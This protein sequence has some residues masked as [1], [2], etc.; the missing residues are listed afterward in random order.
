MIVIIDYGMGNLR[1]VSKALEAIDVEHIISNDPNSL[2]KAD[3]ILLPGVGA[4]GDGM[5]NL[6]QL[7]FVEALEKHV[8]KNKKPLLGICLGM[9]LLAKSSE[10]M[11]RHQ[12]L[13]FIDAEI[14]P[15]DT[16]NFDLKVP[17]VGWN[18]VIYK[19]DSVLFKEIPDSSDFYFV[20]SFHM[21]SENKKIIA[22]ITDYGYD[23]ISSI[24]NENI[25]GCQ[26]HPEKSQKYGLKI[27][28]NFAQL[29]NPLC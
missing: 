14:K 3:K 21:N 25:F 11:G 28:S 27:L 20:H 5:Q 10:E 15:F 16:T 9:Q 22:G 12:G 17:H 1:S 29:K 7:G 23:F 2:D 26:F 6:R 18:N 4:F 13:G 8:I 24:E 19:K